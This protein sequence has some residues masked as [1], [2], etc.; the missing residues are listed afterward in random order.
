MTIHPLKIYLLQNKMKQKEFAQLS[1]IPLITIHRIVN[2]KSF[3][4]RELAKKIEFLTNKQVTVMDL[5]YP[6][7]AKQDEV[8]NA[9]Q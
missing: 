7:V 5:L 3:P 1:G 9:N 4:R 6:E 8:K 2:Y